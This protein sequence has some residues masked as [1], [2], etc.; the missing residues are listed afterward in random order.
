MFCKY[1]GSTIDT[2]TIYCPNC[3]KN[4]N[5][6]G[7]GSAPLSFNERDRNYRDENQNRPP[8][9]VNFFDAIKKFYTNFFNFSGRAVRSEYWW[10]YLYNMLIT[11]V[12]MLLPKDYAFLGTICSIVHFIPGVALCVRRLHDVGKSGAFWFTWL[13]PIAGPFILFYQL[14]KGSSFS[15][16]IWGL[17]PY[18]TSSQYD[19]TKTWKCEKCGCRTPNSYLTCKNCGTIKPSPNVHAHTPPPTEKSKMCA[20]GERVFGKI[21][22]NCGREIDQVKSNASDTIHRWRCD[23]CRN[24]ISAY[25]CNHCGFDENKPQEIIPENC[26]KCMGCGEYVSLE[27]NECECG[28]KKQYL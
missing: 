3:G 6:G 18:N 22:P 24:M 11:V 10:I 7:V 4:Q 23:N 16:N 5:S 2:D 19:E 1:C 26:W 13:I 17:S 12:I 14:C 28:F 27:K 15:D 20:C 21:C 9:S 8:I 25:P